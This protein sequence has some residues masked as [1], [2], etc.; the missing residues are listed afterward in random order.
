MFEATSVKPLPLTKIKE[1]ADSNG[2]IVFK[3]SLMDHIS[4]V[5]IKGISKKSG[6]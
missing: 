6:E 2:K 5:G 4:Y 3:Y 1:T